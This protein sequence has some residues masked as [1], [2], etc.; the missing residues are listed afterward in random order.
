MRVLINGHAH[1]LAEPCTVAAAVTAVGAPERGTAV[2][3]DG[4]LVPRAEWAR[5]E[6][7]PDAR[8]EVLTAVQG[9]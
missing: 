7:T 5:T 1:E 9:G 3:L 8:L 6:L 2:A 4:D